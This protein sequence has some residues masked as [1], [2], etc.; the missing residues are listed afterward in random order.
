MD[1]GLKQKAESHVLAVQQIIEAVSGN[2][3]DLTKRSIKKKY[4]YPIRAANKN[5][6][7]DRQ[8]I[9]VRT[10]KN[11]L[12]SLEYFC[13]HCDLNCKTSLSS[14]VLANLAQLK[15]FLPNWRSSMRNMCKI[16]TVRKRLIDETVAL[17]MEQMMSYLASDY[18]NY[19]NNLL[20]RFAKD[21]RDQRVAS[22]Q[23]FIHGRDHML[24]LMTIANA[25]R[26]GV[27][28]NFS[29]TDYHWGLTM[30][31]LLLKTQN[32]CNTWSSD[33]VW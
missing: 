26:A 27:L 33:S 7:T 29:L 23:D 13:D 15:S 19:A 21:V 10:L 6:T 12:H 25:C 17:T 18:A 4:A 14:D 11:K 3:A 30:L 31:G 16:E 8:I 28:I 5:G 20:G 2:I 22:Q 1:G 32:C 9:S 24:V